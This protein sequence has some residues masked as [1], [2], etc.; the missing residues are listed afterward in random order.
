MKDDEW[1]GTYFALL[2]ETQGGSVD[3][4][5][6]IL[7]RR[8]TIDNITEAHI[9]ANASRWTIENKQMGRLYTDGSVR[10]P[11]Y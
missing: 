4:I 2:D 3:E 11:S 7:R 10:P 6:P 9:R 1:R 8:F 5:I